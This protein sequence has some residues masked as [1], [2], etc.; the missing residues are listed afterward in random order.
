MSFAPAAY[1][2]KGVQGR[3]YGATGNANGATDATLIWKTSKVQ[4]HFT[5]YLDNVIIL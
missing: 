4:V 3:L 2:Y 5:F 1:W